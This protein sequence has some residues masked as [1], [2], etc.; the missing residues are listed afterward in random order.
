MKKAFMGMVLLIG[1]QTFSCAQA[2]E[3][4]EPPK[5]ESTHPLPLQ[6]KQQCNPEEGLRVPAIMF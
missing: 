1:F 3:Q 5:E 4:T 6:K 2:Q